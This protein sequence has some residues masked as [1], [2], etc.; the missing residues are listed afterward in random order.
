MKYNRIVFDL[1]V[2]SVVVCYIFWTIHKEA[3]NDEQ[4]ER[5]SCDYWKDECN[6]PSFTLSPEE[7]GQHAVQCPLMARC[8]D[9]HF[10]SVYHSAFSKRIHAGVEDFKAKASETFCLM[11]LHAPLFAVLYALWYFAP[12]FPKK[13]T[14]GWPHQRLRLESYVATRAEPVNLARLMSLRSQPQPMDIPSRTNTRSSST[15]RDL[16]W[17]KLPSGDFGPMRQEMG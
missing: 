7:H 13:P 6:R 3:K 12:Q 17:F 5:I 8:T 2:V 10:S 14:R 16:N 9:S 1:V 11:G 15:R 4:A